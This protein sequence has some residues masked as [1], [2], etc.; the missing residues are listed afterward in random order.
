MLASSSWDDG[1]KM[2]DVQK[3]EGIP[4]CCIVNHFGGDHTAPRT[5]VMAVAAHGL[6]TLVA[7]FAKLW[8]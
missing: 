3:N 1:I 4:S 2:W 6:R 5:A 8:V 7:A